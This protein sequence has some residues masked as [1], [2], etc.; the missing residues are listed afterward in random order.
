M[1]VDVAKKHDNEVKARVWKE[2]GKK[3]GR[4]EERSTAHTE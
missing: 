1:N 3:R 2:T 4:E